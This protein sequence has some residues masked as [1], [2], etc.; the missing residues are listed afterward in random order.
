MADKWLQIAYETSM[1]AMA[2]LS[3]STNSHILSMDNN[4]IQPV[5]D[6]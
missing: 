5:G 4:H 2:Q 6:N 1:G 3:I